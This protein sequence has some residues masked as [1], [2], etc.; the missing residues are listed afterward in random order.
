M[1]A[2]HA[3]FAYGL[4][5]LHWPPNLILFGYLFEGMVNYALILVALLGSRGKDRQRFFWFYL[6]T[7]GFMLFVLTIFFVMVDFK[8][9]I[10]FSSGSVTAEIL[11]Y[12]LT[13][14]REIGSPSFSFAVLQTIV[15]VI[16]RYGIIFASQ[17][18]HLWGKVAAKEIFSYG[19]API[20][21]SHLTL[22]GAF[23]SVF[24]LVGGLHLPASLVLIA[25]IAAKLFI[26]WFDIDTRVPMAEQL[27]K[28]R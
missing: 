21:R 1:V 4:L 27:K 20:V 25:I 26:D 13:G 6:F 8:T 14:G 18:P 24:F 15:A 11:I 5:R 7:G 19:Y 2:Q 9:K 16:L 10:A 28:E 23:V 17:I 22:F 3:Y 12:L